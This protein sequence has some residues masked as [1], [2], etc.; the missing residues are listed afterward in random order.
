MTFRLVALVLA[1]ALSACGGGAG[2]DG[3]TP[4][5]GCAGDCEAA[6]PIALTVAEVQQVISQAVQEA[7]ARGSA[8]TIAVVDRV[9]NVLAVFKMQGAASTFIVTSDR[10]AVGGL[11]NVDIVPSQF[12]AI[13]KAITGAYLS[14]E[15][16]PL[17]T[18]TPNK[19]FQKNFNPA[20][21]NLPAARLFA[22][23]SSSLPS[24]T[25]S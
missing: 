15:G 25:F 23:Q 17:T 1:A 8:A 12:A 3:G 24:S 6:A 22:V 5:G 9:G 7:Q 16:N 21:I 2:G 11:E 4:P 14:S 20:E 18:R 13:S 19:I 10:G